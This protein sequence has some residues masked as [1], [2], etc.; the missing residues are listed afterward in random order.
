LFGRLWGSVGIVLR[1]ISQWGTLDCAIR[2][3][4][5]FHHSRSLGLF[6]RSGT[7]QIGMPPLRHRAVRVLN[8]MSGR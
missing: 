7:I 4:D 8:Y 6:W 5:K 3:V 2:I 1:A